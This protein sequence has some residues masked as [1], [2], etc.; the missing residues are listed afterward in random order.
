[1]FT[2]LF[3]NIF[4]VDEIHVR[5]RTIIFN[6]WCYFVFFDVCTHIYMYTKVE[7]IFLKHFYVYHEQ[8]FIIFVFLLYI[9]IIGNFS[10]YPIRREFC[11]VCD[12]SSQNCLRSPLC[13]PR[14]IYSWS[15]PYFVEM[16]NK[17]TCILIISFFFRRR[18]KYKQQVP[19]CVYKKIHFNILIRS[20]VYSTHTHTHKIIL[21]F[22][23]QQP[24]NQSLSILWHV[25]TISTFIY[26]ERNNCSLSNKFIA[27]VNA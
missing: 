26:R 7:C 19:F 3:K 4:L 13:I 22:I 24:N 16:Y 14:E 11:N 23:F 10:C 6:T 17:N 25:W 15:L 27:F 5:C 21:A 9:I 12:I 2:K 18:L 1:M 20:V 8:N